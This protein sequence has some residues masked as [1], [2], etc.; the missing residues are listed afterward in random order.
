MKTLC[1]AGEWQRIQ[2]AD[3]SSP[4]ELS[5]KHADSLL[6]VAGRAAR[7]LA[8]PGGA[9]Q[10]VLSDGRAAVQTGQVV[11]ILTAGDIALEILPKIDN[12]DSD[13]A[14]ESLVRMLARTFDLPISDGDMMGV[15]HQQH[16]L[17][18]VLIRLFC[19]RLFNATRGGLPRQYIALEEDLTVVR[20]RLNISRQFSHLMT[21]PQK[22]ACRYDELI[23]D[24]P[25]NQ[26]FKAAV[27]KLR[28]ISRSP[29]NLRQLF[30]LSGTYA[31]ISDV[32]PSALR[33][34][35]ITID[36]M[37]RHWDDLRRFAQLLLGNRFQ[38]TASGAEAGYAL[39]FEMNKLFEE[40][41]GRSLTSA[42][43]QR[44]TLQYRAG[45]ALHGHDGKRYFATIPDIAIHSDLGGLD[46]VVDTKWKR[47]TGPI[48]DRRLGV[49]Q[50]D[51]YQLMAYAQVHACPRVM[52]LY[53]HHAGMGQGA[54]KVADF[55]IT[56][57]DAQLTVATV[58]LSDVC[59]VPVQL[60]S[61]FSAP[62]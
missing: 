48:D 14:R 57:S 1:R 2:I 5:R 4:T 10:Q 33:W 29:D 16:D 27:T 51:V 21:T 6:N 23:T 28:R 34:E 53:P 49:A 12:E 45:H 44:V 32:Q 55:H 20:G 25:L 37:T 58:D 41:V 30:E 31:D 17:L 13:L 46:W 7:H 61:L 24:I 47:L 8:L 54:G 56:G 42:L 62:A 52:L 60:K 59:S 39:L 19:K 35:A 26:V 38:S 3:R 36:R 15:G 22:L 18:E 43:S 40:F 11:G 9:G 50:S